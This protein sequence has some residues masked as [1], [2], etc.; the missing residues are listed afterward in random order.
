VDVEMLLNYLMYFGFPT[1]TRVIAKRRKRRWWKRLFAVSSLI[2]DRPTTLLWR[3]C[4]RWKLS[5]SGVSRTRLAK[6]DPSK[7]KIRDLKK[8]NCICHTK[9][10][11]MLD[12]IF[13]RELRIKAKSD[14]AWVL[15]LTR[16]S[17]VTFFPLLLLC[18]I[19]F[20]IIKINLNKIACIL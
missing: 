10:N 16:A 11:R 9:C 15:S 13:I 8:C 6:R 12:D 4:L 3:G 17:F 18:Y 2:M 20:F 14:T 7:Q 1:R 5:T 19:Y